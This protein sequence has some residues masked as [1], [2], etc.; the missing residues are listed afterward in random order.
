MEAAITW[1]NITAS[2]I[3]VYVGPVELT[4]GEEVL[5]FEISMAVIHTRQVVNVIVALT[6]PSGN[7]ALTDQL[8]S[9]FNKLVIISFLV[10]L[11]VLYINSY[12]P[13]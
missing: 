13:F 2:M 8:R 12:Y 4:E 7:F 3:F 6:T 1:L 10:L 11:L 9:A 5:L